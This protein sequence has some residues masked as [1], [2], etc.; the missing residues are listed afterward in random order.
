MTANNAASLGVGIVFARTERQNSVWVVLALTGLISGVGAAALNRYFPDLRLVHYPI[1]AAAESVGAFA[2]FVVATLVLGLR[3]H[4]HLGPAYTWVAAALIGMGFLDGLHSLLHEG[5]GFVWLHSIATLIGG[6]VFSFVWIARRYASLWWTRRVPIAVLMTSAIIG[7]GSLLF[8][9]MIPAMV[10]DEEFT[11]VARA[12]NMVGGAGF[13]IASFYFA[14]HTKSDADTRNRLIFSSHCFLFGISGIIFEFSVI[15]DAAWWFWHILRICAYL[16]AVTFYFGLARQ[17]ETELYDL[18]RNLEELVGDRTRELTRSNRALSILSTCGKVI[19]NATTEKALLDEACHL[20]IAIGEYRMVW[21]GFAENDE[22]KTIRPIAQR[23]YEDGYLDRITVTWADND[24]GSGPVGTAVRTGEPCVV[25]HIQEDPKFKPWKAA[26]IE[27][28]Y[29]S[30]IALPLIQDRKPFGAIAIYSEF[31]DAFDDDEAILLTELASDLSFGI[32][33]IRESKE[34]IDAVKKAEIANRAKTE[35]LANMSH[36]L[37]TPLNAIIGFSETIKGS[38]FGPLGNEQYVQYAEYI[39]SSGQHLLELINDILD[40]SAIEA[41]KIQLQETKLNIQEVCDAALRI[42]QPKAHEGCLTLKG[43]SD[44][45]LPSLWGDERRLKQIF[46][47]LLSNAVKFTPEN[48]VVSCDAFID[49]EG[50]FNILVTDTG[51]GMDKKGMETALTSFGQIDG[52]LARKH[53]G[54]GLGLPLT[55]GL[56]ELHGGTLELESEPNKG[57]RVTVKF[58]PSRVINPL[59]QDQPAVAPLGV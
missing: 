33:A 36:E 17:I 50:A 54:T 10:V 44:P 40:V 11:L 59:Q 57:T 34:R 52:S 53:E 7:V 41:G 37:R 6:V 35:L 47:N 30:V 13:L 18:K 4:G 2:A 31:A 25:R 49:D 19:T 27:R 48:G 58:P 55:K 20:I 42:L 23:G 45:G 51:I 24:L 38:M 29:S 46:L 3:N 12:S 28:G 43:L 15:W 21:I 39:H 1:H 26:A 9:E 14:L 5:P 32:Q 8:P 16:I 56:V 22:Q